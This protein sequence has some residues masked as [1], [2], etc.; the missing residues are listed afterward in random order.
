MSE[1]RTTNSATRIPMTVTAPAPTNAAWK[2]SVSA[3][4]KALPE[5]TASEVVDVAIDVSAAIPSAPPICWDVLNRPEAS[6]ASD[7]RTPASAAIE[8]G[9]N[10]KPRPTETSRKPGNRSPTYEP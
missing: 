9:T 2:P 6:P 1:L 8:I 3:T 4:G 10:E 5:A 7:D